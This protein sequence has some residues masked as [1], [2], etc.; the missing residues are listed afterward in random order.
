M[1]IEEVVKRYCD[2][3]VGSDCALIDID[4]G[5][6][7]VTTD[8]VPEPAAMVIG[9]DHDPYWKGWLLVTI[10]ASDLAASAAKPIAF[11]A[12]IEAPAD[13]PVDQFERLLSG[14]SDACK[15]E[16]LRYVGGNL[17]ESNRVTAVGTAIGWVDDSQTLSRAGILP[18]DTLAVIGT[19]GAFWNDALFCAASGSIPNVEA[20]PLFKPRSQLRYMRSLASRVS[21]HA[22]MDNSDGLL[23]TFNQ[24]CKS[25]K[26]ALSIDLEKFTA[27][28][29]YELRRKLIN[30]S[31]QRLWLGWGDWNVAVAI[32]QQDEPE[33]RQ[34][35]IENNLDITVCGRFEEGEPV[36]NLGYKGD[37][38]AAPRI[39]SER[40][41]ADSWFTVGIERYIEILKTAK[42]P[43]GL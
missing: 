41:S 7:V 33:L 14:I 5:R 22:A 21:L 24:L 16:G 18:G 9:K 17:R 38:I 8:P 23:P 15:A 26:L 43:G 13:F 40:F 27:P 25:N 3:V 28:Q 30:I 36:V 6:I 37:V 12:A 10:N 19:G 31:P 35:S 29:D 20:S 39:E 32:S 1:I 11:L 34:F 2:P 4:R 42:M